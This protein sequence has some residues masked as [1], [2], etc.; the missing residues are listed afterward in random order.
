[1]PLA[2]KPLFRD[3]IYDGAADPVVI[4]NRVEKW[5]FMLYTNRRATMTDL[6][7]VAWVHGTRLGIAESV[8][9]GATWAYRGTANIHYGKPDDAHWAPDVIW[10][11]GLYHMYL[12]HVPGVHVDWSGTRDLIHLTSTNLID[13]EYR[14]TLNLASNR[15]IDASIIQLPDGSW[16]MWYNDEF[17]NK[18]IR[19]ADSSDLDHWQDVARVPISEPGEGPKVFRF[20]NRFWMV[21]DHWKGLGAYQSQDAVR[22]TRQPGYLLATP[23]SGAD[24]GAIGNHADVLVNGSRAYIFYFTHPGRFAG[25]SGLDGYEQRR[26]SIQVAELRVEGD[27]LVCD[28]DQPTE[29]NMRAD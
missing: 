15:V 1:M 29:I 23:G 26:S 6:P 7:G 24:D 28:R 16:R 21:V 10:H 2:A 12:S 22:W 11:E 3:S 13:W 25:A 5:W 17:D 18:A 9:G 14:S 27:Q 20:A 8:D 4:W 19:Y